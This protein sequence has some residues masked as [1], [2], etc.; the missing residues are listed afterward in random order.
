ML[1]ENRK[2][3]MTSF[4]LWT[5]S[6][7]LILFSAKCKYGCCFLRLEA[8]RLTLITDKMVRRPRARGGRQ[9]LDG[10]SHCPWRS[11]FSALYYSRNISRCCW[12]KKCFTTGFQTMLS[13]ATSA[14]L[15]WT[16]DARNRSKLILLTW[17]P[18]IVRKKCTKADT[19]L[20]LR[21]CMEVS[22][23]EVPQK[24]FS[25]LIDYVEKLQIEAIWEAE[26]VFRNEI[27]VKSK[28]N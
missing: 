5:A 26:T 8:S 3:W 20:K 4:L 27:G 1:V 14:I 17:S 7:T 19:A 9:C 23:E 6:L 16:Q 12:Y 22:G 15:L 10:L 2:N 25:M 24:N 18:L 11:V 28:T 13:G 21:A